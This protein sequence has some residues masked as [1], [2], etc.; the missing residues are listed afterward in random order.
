LGEIEERISAE[1]DS[2]KQMYRNK[3][4]NPL[5]V[6]SALLLLTVPIANIK[7]GSLTKWFAKIAKTIQIKYYFVTTL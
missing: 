2:P 7:Q 6:I 4:A 1:Q 5:K 3:R